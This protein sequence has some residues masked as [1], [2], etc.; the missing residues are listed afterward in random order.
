[1]A[2]GILP[3]GCGGSPTFVPTISQGL[4]GRVVVYKGNCMPGAGECKIS[5]PSRRVF[6]REPATDEQISESYLV[7]SVGLVATTTADKDGFYEVSL[8]PGTYSVFVEDD[9]KEYCGFFGG[10]HEACQVAIGD[11]LTEREL[12][13]DHAAW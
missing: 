2:G 11:G 7:R 6:I 8:V 10:Q 5:H 3:L 4:Y 12:Q 1:M 9:G 13:I